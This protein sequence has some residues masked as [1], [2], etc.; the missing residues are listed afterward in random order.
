MNT[1]REPSV[2]SADVLATGSAAPSSRHRLRWR[3]AAGATAALTVLAVASC[4]SGGETASSDSGGAGAEA[5]A[6]MTEDQAGGVADRDLAS[7]SEAAAVDGKSV[8]AAALATQR[9]VISTG[10]V[11]LRS[12]DVGELRFDVRQVVDE[13]QGQVTDEETESDADG[14]VVRSRLVVRVPAKQFDATMTALQ[15]VGTVVSAQRTSEDVTTQVIDTDVRVRAQEAS[16]RR[17]ESLLSEA[18]SLRDIVAIEAQLT[19]RQADLDSL[20]Q[21]QAW[22]A[23]QTS[24]STINVQLRRSDQAATPQTEERGFLAGLAAGWRGLQKVTTGALT[25]VGA[26]LPFAVVLLGVG[27][28]L[29]L[30]VRRLQRR[31][32]PPGPGADA[33][34][35]A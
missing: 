11:A 4:S 31:R 6:A 35:A 17:I 32:Q 27:L 25:A 10:V 12:T 29:W 3:V 26:V 21:Q 18:Q 7:V 19:R 14:V 28:P 23:D 13:H 22:L 2:L 8:D 34:A 9:S 20:K 1:Q 16:L 30:V 33:P 15:D 5:P 24:M